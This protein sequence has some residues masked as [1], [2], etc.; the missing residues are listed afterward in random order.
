MC[1]NDEMGMEETSLSNTVIPPGGHNMGEWTVDREPTCTEMGTQ[2]RKCDYCEYMEA[3]DIDPL[4][5][6]LTIHAALQTTCIKAGNVEYWTCD[7]C[8]TYF[9][10]VNANAKIMAGE[11]ISPE[12]K[13]LVATTE[14]KVVLAPLGH[15]YGDWTV[16]KKATSEEAGIE[17]RTCATCGGTEE[18]SIP[19]LTADKDNTNSVVRDVVVTATTGSNNSSATTAK[20]DTDKT[21]KTGDESGTAVAIAGIFFFLALLAFWYLVERHRKKETR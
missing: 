10:E 12:G 7:T 1:F 14:E 8:G 2:I 6:D 18:R 17:T 3:L 5:H 4:G 19:R 11:I 20:A 13:T 21:V 16:T 9:V 15:S